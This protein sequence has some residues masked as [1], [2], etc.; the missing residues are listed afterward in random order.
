[1]KTAP[2]TSRPCP[3]RRR[4]SNSPSRLECDRLVNSFIKRDDLVSEMSVVRNEFERGENSPTAILNQRIYAA[5]Y[6]WHNYGKS[7]IGNRSDIERVPIERLQDFYRKY[8]Q[9]DNVVLII[10]GKFDEALASVVKIPRFDS[11]TESRS[12]RHLYRGA[13]T[14][15][16]TNGDAATGGQ[17]RFRRSWIS[18]PCG[19][20]CRLGAALL[21]GRNHL[22]SSQRPAL[23]SDGRIEVGDERVRRLR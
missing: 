13:C 2:I 18:R 7:T 15:R 20:S 8:Y 3:P 6:E 4:T 11:K 23:Q 5:A 1:M 9:P 12:R 10:T 17:G 21:T 19:L 22:A 14:G 16:R